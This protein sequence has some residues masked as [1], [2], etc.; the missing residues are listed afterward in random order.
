MGFYEEL[1][2][3]YDI[4]FPATSDKIDFIEKAADNGKYVLDIACGTG[5][6][7]IE[8]AKKG[9]IVDGIDL[10]AAMIEAGKK[11]AK[12]EDLDINLVQGDMKDINALF[13]EKK[14]DL[15]Y[16]IGNSLVHLDNEAE[17][18]HMIDDIGKIIDNGGKLLIQIINYDRILDFDIDHLPTIS[19]K[20]LGVEFVRNYILDRE[21]RKI[22]FN[23]EIHISNETGRQKYENSVALLPLRK[24]A[25]VNIVKKAGFNNIKVYGGFNEEEYTE[26]SFATVLIA[27]K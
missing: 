12:K 18:Q 8:L 15:A 26:N 27:E 10:D 4:I 9:Y 2:R 23:T 22:L 13:S 17:I 6:Y 11:K 1:S 16:C 3:Y 19:K 20:E 25:L 21:S 24:E 7:A 5:N 14:Y